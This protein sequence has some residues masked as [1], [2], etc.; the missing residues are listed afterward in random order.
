MD[1]IYIS[2]GSNL[3]DPVSNCKESV[4]RLKSLPFLSVLKV[5]SFYETEPWGVVDEQENYINL[6]LE[7]ETDLSPEKLLVI[8]KGMEIAMGRVSL[9]KWQARIIDL[10]IIFYGNAVLESSRLTIPH[11]YCHQRR[12]VLEP[13]SEIAPD[14]IHPL[15]NKSIKSLL[16]SLIDDSL[17]KKLVLD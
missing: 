10:D 14:F 13:L 8:L 1:N 7:L 11:P 17:C 4:H 16:D 15:F 5:S 12:F 9:E 3:N 6:A 2:I